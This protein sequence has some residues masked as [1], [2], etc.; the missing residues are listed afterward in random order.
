MNVSFL[1]AL[2]NSTALT[3]AAK[4]VALAQANLESAR[5]TS[6][7]Y[8]EHTNPFGMKYRP[9]IATFADPVNYAASDGVGTYAAFASDKDAVAGYALFVETGPYPIPADESEEAY[10]DALVVGG[11]ATDP[12]YKSKLMSLLPEARTMLAGVNAGPVLVSSGPAGSADLSVLRKVAI[13]VGHNTHGKGAYAPA[14]IAES[15]YYFNSDVAERMED[16]G[17]E[18]GID[19][20]IFYREP[21][22]PYSREIDRVYAAVNASGAEAS[23]E[24]HFNA[25]SGAAVG[26]ET[27]SSGFSGSLSLAN[28]VQDELVDLFDRTG[29]A[30]RGVLIRTPSQRGGRSLHAGRAPAILTEPFFGST[31]S[32]RTLMQQIGKA[33]L[34]EA[35]VSGIARYLTMV[36]ISQAA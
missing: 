7:L 1:T 35:Y 31:T 24:L 22:L 12:S 27:L 30:D 19:F 11:Y 4:I 32:E 29:S 20:D 6:P 9:R 10:I 33:G 23:V 26:T 13:V 36:G 15:E 34:A 25:A 17:L 21:H 8:T 16:L 3:Q 2:T 14:P 5:G 28:A 18:Y